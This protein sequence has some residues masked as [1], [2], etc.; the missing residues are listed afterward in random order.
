MR[1]VGAGL[2]RRAEADRGLAGDHR[3]LVGMAGRL[4]GIGDRFRI[5]AVDVAGVPAGR[6]E[7]GDLIGVVG[8]RHRAIDRDVVVVPKDDQ[9]VQ[10]E[11]SGKRDG[12][13]RNAFHQAAVAGQHIG[14]MVDKVIAEGGIHD[15]LA[16]CEADR[17]GKPLAERA[18]RRLDAGGMAVF[19][20]ACRPRSQLAE[21]LDLVE[22]DVLVAGQVEQ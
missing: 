2:G 8:Q 22:G 12:L 19:G 9:L 4:D 13:L 18:G 15:A 21:M 11:M 6:L 10:L 17:I 14:V 7:A 1:L 5:L 3:R 16:E 20:M